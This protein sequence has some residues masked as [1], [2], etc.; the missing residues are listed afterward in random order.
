MVGGIRSIVIRYIKENFIY[1]SVSDGVGWYEKDNI[2][3]EVRDTSIAVWFDWKHD[4]WGGS[5]FV[6]RSSE[7]WNT[8]DYV[9]AYFTIRG[10]LNSND[11]DLREIGYRAFLLEWNEVDDANL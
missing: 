7:N 10:L 5:R 3:I 11:E 1:V 8:A 4:G 6:F 9:T 2:V